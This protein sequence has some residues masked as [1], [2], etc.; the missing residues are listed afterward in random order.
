MHLVYDL[1]EYHPELL[2]LSP[3]LSAVFQTLLSSTTLLAPQIVL[4]TLDALRGI[5]G[6][7][8]L[9]S[10]SPF[11][12]A[13]GS[14]IRTV[15]DGASGALIPALLGLL[16]DGFE[17]AAT[18]ILTILRLLAVQFPMQLTREVPLAV[19]Q[20]PGKTVSGAER[21][22]FLTKFTGCVHPSLAWCES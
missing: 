10:P 4:S 13:F 3:S 22:E 5:V 17:D 12:A 19:E 6:H 18:N 15:V 1:L 14:A 2:L 8:S 11:P 21:A 20:L 7:E 9:Q 16:V